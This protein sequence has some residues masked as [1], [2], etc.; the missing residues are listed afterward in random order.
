MVILLIKII[1]LYLITETNWLC[2][3][4]KVI[5]YSGFTCDSEVIVTELKKI[6]IRHF[7]SC[8]IEVIEFK[9]SG[10]GEGYLNGTEGVLC[11]CWLYFSDHGLN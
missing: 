7:L 10:E 3:Y 9:E 6:T 5:M 2:C 4:Q 11:I 8:D 1:R